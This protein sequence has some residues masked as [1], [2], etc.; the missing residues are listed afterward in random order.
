MTNIRQ[1]TWFSGNYLLPIK[2][3]YDEF[4]KT[5]LDAN[6]YMI[7]ILESDSE[8]IISFEYK[9]LHKGFRGSIQGTPNF[10]VEVDKASGQILRFSY[11]R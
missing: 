10:Q 2:H 8:V 5:G 7:N 6:D 1:I 3:A 9:N 4:S 11:D